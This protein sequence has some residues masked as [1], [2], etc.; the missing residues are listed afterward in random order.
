MFVNINFNKTF[1]KFIIITIFIVLLIFGMSIHKILSKSSKI[2]ISNNTENIIEIN[3]NN[4]TNVLKA[5]HESPEKY[6]GKT[7]KF[8]GYIYRV[9]DLKDTE[10]V[11]ARNMII[12]PDNKAVVVGFLCNCNRASEFDNNTWVEITGTITLGNYHGDMPIIEVT[13]IENVNCPT[14]EYVYP[15]DDS[16]IPTNSII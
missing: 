13:K 10:F 8:V 12:S 16:F 11:L 5:V 4:Y 1:K 15:P 2:T 6:I 14:D 9:F 3:S 7:I